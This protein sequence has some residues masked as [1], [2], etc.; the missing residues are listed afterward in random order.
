MRRNKLT[1]APDTAGQL[2]QLLRPQQRRLLGALALAVSASLLFIWQC[3]LLSTL[4]ATWLSGSEQQPGTLLKAVLPWLALCLLG[5]PVLQYCREQLSLRA[6]QQIRSNLRLQLLTKLAA[7]GPGKS[8]YGS[9]GSLSSKLLEQV[10]AL[11]GFISRYYVQR[12]LVLLSPVLLVVATVIYSPLAAAILLITAPLVP[13]FMVLLGNAATAASQRQLQ[14]L[15]RMSGRFLDLVRGMATLQQLQA[16]ER[17][18]QAVADAAEHYRDSSMGVLKLAF[19]SGAVL[20]FFSAL[21][22]ALL[23]L[24]LGLGLLGILPWAKG[25]IPVP[26]QGALFILLLAPEFYAPLRQL[27]S[28]YH[29]KAQAEAAITELSP[30]LHSHAWQ[31]PGTQQLTLSS[32]PQITLQQLHILTAEQR[33]RLAPVSFSIHSGGRIALQGPSGCGKSSLLHALLG[34]VPYQGDIL[35]NQHSLLQL[36]LNHWQQQ[37]GYMAQHSS[38]A[39]ASIA[40]NL[41]LAAPDATEPQLITALQQV[42]LWPL[43][44]QLPLGL[45]TLLGERGLGLSGGQLQRLAL[46]QLLLRDAKVWLLDEPTAHLD[47]ATAYRLHQLIG[48]LSQG[49]TLI[50][51]S[52]Q[53]HGLDWLDNVI[54]LPNPAVVTTNGVQHASA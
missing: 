2:K 9:D 7:A 34:F 19:L 22:I 29:A 54:R 23:A 15:S 32:A 21:A 8:R 28:D 14:L 40:D 17:A 30:I 4:F 13:L 20:E 18:T 53:L 50:I 26:Y 45:N 43:V 12:Y 49:K 27:G 31:H 3:Y 48:T 51:V 46:A 16:T 37:L 24:Y 6:S 11:D 5:R 47:G 33:L 10:D 25:E 35:I 52:H 42:E 38:I 36:G 41:R 1:S 39:A 44:Q